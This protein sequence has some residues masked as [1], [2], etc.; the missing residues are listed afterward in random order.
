MSSAAAESC[1][2]S[3]HQER[4]SHIS[5]ECQQAAGRR[6]CSASPEPEGREGKENK[7]R[8]GCGGNHGPDKQQPVSTECEE[9]RGP[10]FPDDDSNQ[11]LPVEHFFGNM[12][13]VQVRRGSFSLTELV[14][15]CIQW[16]DQNFKTIFSEIPIS[17]L[18]RAIT[19]GLPVS[20][21]LES[22]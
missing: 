3:G 11:I 18:Y 4:D 6:R 5:C 7:D 19:L 17:P 22:I 9:S 16:P 13:I 12:D 10:F 20:L 1:K 14:F 8:D 2:A 15:C 21:L